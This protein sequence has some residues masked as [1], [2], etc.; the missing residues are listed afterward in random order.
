MQVHSADSDSDLTLLDEMAQISATP[1][2]VDDE[3][4]PVE[5]EGLKQDW[6]RVGEL[7]QNAMGVVSIKE[8]EDSDTGEKKDS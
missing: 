2:G 4:V 7:L 3:T 5:L 8:L 1:L 6:D